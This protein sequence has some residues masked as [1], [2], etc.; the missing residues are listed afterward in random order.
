MKIIVIILLLLPFWG[1]SQCPTLIHQTRQDAIE[2]IKK[3]DASLFNMF[4][5]IDTTQS[6]SV[7]FR[8]AQEFCTLRVDFDGPIGAQI[9]R[10]F[11]IKGPADKIEKFYNEQILS[12][13]SNCIESKAGFWILFNH[14]IVVYKND[15]GRLGVTLKSIEIDY[16][17]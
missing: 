10:H 17:K 12:K 5:E 1:L 16:S 6:E 3:A 2:L 8:D 9:A 15:G 11:F 4:S 14:T 13:V 7:F